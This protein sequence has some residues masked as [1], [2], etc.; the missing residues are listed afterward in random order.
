MSQPIQRHVIVE[1]DLLEAFVFIGLENPA[2]A[3]RFLVAAERTI[4]ELAAAPGM[5][6]QRD[7]AE[8]QLEGLRSWRIRGFENWLVF[9]RSIP[10]GIEVIRVLHGARDLDDILE[11]SP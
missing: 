2:A 8:S 7:F 4:Q 11:S 5:G 6:R 10:G 1:E 3:Y 9:Y